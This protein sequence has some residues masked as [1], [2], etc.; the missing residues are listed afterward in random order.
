MRNGA[1]HALS[2][3]SCTA[4]EWPSLDCNQ[5]HSAAG[6]AG[7]STLT[8]LAYTVQAQLFARALAQAKAVDVFDS[9]MLL[10]YSVLRCSQGTWW[11]S[12]VAAVNSMQMWDGGRDCCEEVALR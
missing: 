9:S 4:G 6:S 7:H 10:L 11:D 3:I 1:R 12:C 5:A 8:R 2:S